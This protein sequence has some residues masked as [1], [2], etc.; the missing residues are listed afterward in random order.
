MELSRCL[1]CDDADKAQM[2]ALARRFPG[3]NL[4]VIDLPYRLSSWALDDPEN[5]ALWFDD[6]QLVAWG[7]LQT[8]FWTLDIVCHPGVEAH[9]YPQILAWAERRARAAQ[10]TPF[11]HPAWF[12]KAFSGQAARLQALEQA[13]YRCQSDVGE[14]SWSSVLMR[15][16]VEAPLKSYPPP[17]GF[18]LRPLAG[19]D[20][21]AAYVALHQAVFESKNMSVE[22]RQ[23]TLRH[24]AYKPELDIVAAATGGRLAAFCVCWWDEATLCG[25]VEPLGCHPDFRRYALGRVALAEGLRRLQALGAKYIYVETDNYRDTAFRLYESFDFEVIQDVVIYRRDFASE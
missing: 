17:P 20:E 18:T 6:G 2:S 9:L 21:V 13:G 7:V 25:Q 14:D 11:G 24:P 1:S 15:R 8:P 4:H 12:V 23:R 3:D 10:H 19:E 22:W 5:V 16:A